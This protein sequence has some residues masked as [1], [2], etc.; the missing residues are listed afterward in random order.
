MHSSKH[1]LRSATIVAGLVVI[2]IASRTIFHVVPNVELVTALSLLAG[3]YLAGWSAV[4]VPLAIMVGSDM[5]LG[6]SNIFLF[7]WSAYVLAGLGGLLLRRPALNKR[8]VLSATGAGVVFS[9][10]FFLF[11]NF[12]VW[13]ITPWYERSV[14][15]LMYAYYMGLPFLKLNLLGNLIL[16][17]M[18]FGIARLALSFWRKRATQASVV[19]S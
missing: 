3:C 15:G 8:I 12:G 13:L 6:N 19:K 16:V 7:T 17:P 14:S 1:I 2:G 11:T 9:L 18:T 10:F 4:V 5:V